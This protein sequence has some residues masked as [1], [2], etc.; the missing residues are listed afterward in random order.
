MPLGRARAR[1]EQ[2]GLRRWDPGGRRS[3]SEG[4]SPPGLRPRQNPPLQSLALHWPFDPQQTP[5]GAELK[6]SVHWNT[7]A[8]QAL[9][10]G[11]QVHVRLV[12][13]STET[14]VVVDGILTV[15]EDGGGGRRKEPEMII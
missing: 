8:F 5:P 13:D 15:Q 14:N 12:T 4:S 9:S 6:G 3:E 11:L 10:R 2:N 1:G 7:L